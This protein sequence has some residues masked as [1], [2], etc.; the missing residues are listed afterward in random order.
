MDHIFFDTKTLIINDHLV[1][2]YLHEGTNRFLP[3]LVFLH[4][5]RSE[6]KAWEAVAQ[7]CAREGF[8]VCLIDLP[9]F[10]KSEVPKRAFSVDD[11]A[12]IVR[13]VVQKLG[14]VEHVLVGHSFGG[15]IAIKLAA[16]SDSSVRKLVLVD[17]AGIRRSEKRKGILKRV[18]TLF[19]PLVRLAIFTSLRKRAYSRMGA[20]DYLARPELRET[21]VRVIEENLEPLLSSI[22]APTLLIWG[23]EDEATPVEDARRMERHIPHSKLIVFEGAGHYSFL[24]EHQRFCDELFEFVKGA[25]ENN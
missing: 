25:A 18:S 2:A 5:W 4:G 3:P 10:G 22:H 15:R 21:F 1:Q 23:S 7:E 11:Y 6:A 12:L 8:S 9:G 13:T 14:L 17:A 20:E 19:R 16:E 24:D